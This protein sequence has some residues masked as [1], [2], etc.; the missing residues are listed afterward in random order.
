LGREQRSLTVKLQHVLE[1]G[2]YPVATRPGRS[3]R[4]WTCEN[5]TDIKAVW[6]LLQ[7]C[8]DAL[9]RT[10]ARCL[11]RF[12]VAKLQYAQVERGRRRTGGCRT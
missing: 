4:A 2:S 12:E 8:D 6:R 11:G 10:G 1:S 7:K 5:P 9:R 3:A